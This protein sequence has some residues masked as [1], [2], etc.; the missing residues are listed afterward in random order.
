MKRRSYAILTSVLAAS[1]LVLSLS[2]CSNKYIGSS[3]PGAGNVKAASAAADY[4][5]RLFDTSYVHTI[6]IAIS[7]EDWSDLKA[8]PL[9]K[10]KYKV[11]ITIDGETIDSVSFATKGNTSLSSIAS[12]SDSDRYSFKV[13][14]GKY[15]KGQ[16]Y[17]GLDKLNLNNIYADATYM[18]DYLSY[19]LFR[20]AGVDAPL[21]SYVWLTINGEDH[22]L[23]I[24]IEDISDGYLD[25]ADNGEGE[26]YKPE[27]E[28]LANMGKPG[29]MQM[30]NGKDGEMPSMPK[31]G[32]FPEG[33]TPPENGSFPEG[34][35]FPGN[36]EMP[37]MPKDGSFPEGMTPPKNGERPEKPQGGGDGMPGGFGGFSGF[38]S[39]SSGADLK[40]IDDEIGSYSDIFDNAETDADDEAKQRVIAALKG[41]SEGKD[42]EKYLVP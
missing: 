20:E 3:D 32:S 22:G 2:G 16:T 23:Y 24:A 29:N 6:D 7:G 21:V 34:M 13:N 26:L 11:N 5:S 18:K 10:T 19:E 4:A 14:F 39:S 8:N 42:L 28:M 37:S 17:Y 12:D 25:R 41:L 35:T 30:P 33:M 9:E 15:N 38:G 40:Y 27:S 36:G 1:A 31:D